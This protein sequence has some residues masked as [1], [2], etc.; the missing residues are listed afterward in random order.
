MYAKCLSGMVPGTELTFFSVHL[1]LKVKGQV[2]FDSDELY[3]HTSDE[4][5]EDSSEDSDLCHSKTDQKMTKLRFPDLGK[6]ADVRD[7]CLQMT[8]LDHATLNLNRGRSPS[9]KE[10]TSG[11]W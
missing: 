8:E 10:G 5:G 9:R 2:D 11:T 1:L 6:T 4:S 7:G 3:D